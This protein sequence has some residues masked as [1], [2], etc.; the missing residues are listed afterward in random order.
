MDEA[1]D[2]QRGEEEAQVNPEVGNQEVG[3]EKVKR[4]QNTLQRML[5][6]E[7][8]MPMSPEYGQIDERDVADSS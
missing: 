3:E 7:L 8:L 4:K 1:G 5:G 2:G 6:D